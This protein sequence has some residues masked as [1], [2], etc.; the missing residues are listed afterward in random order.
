MATSVGNPSAEGWTETEELLAVSLVLGS[1]RHTAVQPKTSMC[2]YVPV[3]T[4]AIFKC[5]FPLSHTEKGRG[6]GGVG[7]GVGGARI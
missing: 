6:G 5:V 2:V 1:L 7:G 4:Y 3:C